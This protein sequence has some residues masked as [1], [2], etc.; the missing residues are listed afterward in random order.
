MEITKIERDNANQ[1]VKDLNIMASSID[2]LVN[3]LSGGN[4]QKVSISKWLN[5]KAE[6]L[7]LDEPTKGIDVGSKNEIY[8]LIR[9]L[10]DSGTSI[11][12][13]SSE[14]PEIVN[15][16]DRVF[17]FKEGKIVKEFLDLSNITDHDILKYAI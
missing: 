8:K 1:Y 6:I 15:L 14:L 5:A 2:N 3:K 17:I 7:I 16:S 9:N 4:Q 11:I 13:I 12:F 10:A